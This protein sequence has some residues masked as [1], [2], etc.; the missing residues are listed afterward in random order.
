M[1]LRAAS[2]AAPA[3]TGR[4][5]IGTPRHDDGPSSGPRGGDRQQRE[6]DRCARR[7]RNPHR[8]APCQRVSFNERLRACARWR[9]ATPR[10]PLYVLP[11]L[12]GEQSPKGLRR[13]SRLQ[14]DLRRIHLLS[15]G[16]CS[17]RRGCAVEGRP[18]AERACLAAHVGD[19]LSDLERSRSASRVGGTARPAA[20]SSRTNHRGC[21]DRLFTRN[22]TSGLAFLAPDSYG[23]LWR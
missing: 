3:R 10:N 8:R 17:V 20:A 9:F 18:E 16:A 19:L 21:R 1:G 13:S 6:P 12:S 11:P 15:I 23:E 22:A 2:R 14:L 4:P 5:Q 7:G